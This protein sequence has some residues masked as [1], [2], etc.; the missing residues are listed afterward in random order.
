MYAKYFICSALWDPRR[1]PCRRKSVA[2]VEAHPSQASSGL[3]VILE[4]ISLRIGHL[5]FSWLSQ[6]AY[7][8]PWSRF[9]PPVSERISERLSNAVSRSQEHL[10][11]LNLLFAD[12]PVN[13][14]E[15]YG[16]STWQNMNMFKV[17]L[18]RK[19][20]TGRSTKDDHPSHI[21]LAP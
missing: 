17:H 5:F 19:A 6:R 14:A 12:L 16:M 4:C 11:S 8:G 3:G 20:E 1:P 21:T 18:A 15:A 10:Q 2:V 9:M 13:G 7:N